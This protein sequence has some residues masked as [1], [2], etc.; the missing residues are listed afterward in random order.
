M[1]AL[2]TVAAKDLRQRIR[3]KSLLLI[4]VVAPFALASIVGLALGN[5]GDFS[6]EIA[7]ADDDGTALTAPLGEILRSPG[8]SDVVTVSDAANEAAVRDAVESGD[9]AA[10]LVVPDGFAAAVMSGRPADL[11]VVVEPDN[12]ISGEL[13]TSV[14]R[15]F[16]ANI[17]AGQVA[18][19]TIATLG[20]RA[21]GDPAAVAARAAQDLPRIVFRNDATS[22]EL[23]PIDSMAPSMSILFLFFAVLYGAATV[24]A[25]RRS[26][27]L[28]RLAVAP[29]REWTVLAGKLLALFLTGL[30][31]FAVMIVSTTLAYGVRWGD[32]LAVT[33]LACTTTAAAI[34]ITGVIAVL[35]RTE[36]QVRGIGTAIVMLLAIAGGSFFGGQL[37]QFLRTMQ[38]LTPNGLALVGFTRLIVTEGGGSLATVWLAIVYT[39]AVG[40]AG[41]AVTFALGRK[42]FRS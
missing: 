5:V 38:E 27:T 41:I 37:P 34:G 10:G 22:V 18:T 26:R 11:V 6:T 31:I 9:A 25:E 8:L 29:V 23:R 35:A 21:V 20:G 28:A 17:R 24:Q 2:L 40:V 19:G 7:Y 33:L 14:A 15:G 12:E 13:A 32:P 1:R 42:A 16:V 3:D 39:A 30:L 4:G 36:E